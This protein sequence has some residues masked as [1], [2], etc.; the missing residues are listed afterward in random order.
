[1]KSA[2]TSILLLIL[3]NGCLTNQTPAIK[4]LLNEQ[5]LA[6]QFFTVNT[7]AD[8][9][10]LTKNGCVIKIPKGA[11]AGSSQNIKLEIKE[12]LSNTDIVMAG[13]T[14]MSGK[15]PLSSGGMIY[16]NA[17]SGY[18]IEIK[19]QIEVLVPT[20]NYNRDMQ[21]FKGDTVKGKIDWQQPEALPADST[22]AKV[23]AGKRLFLSNCA[24]CHKVNEDF[25][26]PAL[27]GIT[28]RKNWDWIYALTVHDMRILESGCRE[29]G[30]DAYWGNITDT[31][32]IKYWRENADNDHEGEMPETIKACLYHRCLKNKYGSE[33]TSFMGLA[34][35]DVKNIYAYVKSESDKRPELKE[36]F[37]RNC[38]DSCVDYIQANLGLLQ[39]REKL[40]TENGQFFNLDRVIPVPPQDT[41][42]YE[43]DTTTILPPP[44]TKVTPTSVKATYYTINIKTVGWYN[45]DILM[46]DYNG[47]IE[48]ELFV[49]LQGNYDLD[50]NINLIIPQYKVFVEGGKLTDGEQYG[51][52]ENDGKIKLP[53]NAK[54]YIIAFAEKDDKLIF[55]KKEFNT[56]TKQTIELVFTELSKQQLKAEITSLK[57]DNVDADV[58]DSKNAKEI[59]V[60]DKE[61]K[62]TENLKPKNCDC[63]FLLPHTDTV[64][65]KNN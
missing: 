64:A 50:V 13:L 61:L 42:V 65:T 12:A 21:V 1:M 7:E 8:T 29:G 45:I 5:N 57:L 28:E 47:C 59:K 43:E 36:K 2:F 10:L 41:T 48:S 46:K 40:K 32:H 54:A 19:K 44:Y 51:F 23:D 52:D 38:C 53:Q 18:S 39:Q 60:I 25:T 37:G 35:N 27:Y 11:I 55:S 3:L 24:S 15:L 6:S 58:K 17:A 31:G 30:G 14:T 34:E 20:K 9:T 4:G 26:G 22:T 56:Q 16:F 62:K 33:M 63:D 49:R